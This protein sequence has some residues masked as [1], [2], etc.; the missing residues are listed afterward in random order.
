VE[1]RRGAER[2]EGWRGGGERAE[3]GGE[4]RGV[5]RNGE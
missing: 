5:E 2:G 3:K 4:G 1:W